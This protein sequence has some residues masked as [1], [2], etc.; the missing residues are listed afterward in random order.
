MFTSKNYISNIDDVPS[1]WIFEYYLGTEPLHGQRIQLKSIFN[2]DDKN[3]SMYIYFD[4]IEQ[5][6]KFKCFSTG[7]FGHAINLVM[8]LTK[9][10]FKNASEQII[11]DYKEFLKTGNHVKGIIYN[12]ER[13]QVCK[14]DTRSFSK[15]DA[16]YWSAYN[17]SSKLLNYWNVV[18]LN[19]YTMC[20]EEKSFDVRGLGI[21]GFFKKNG[22]LY[23]IYQPFIRDRKF[24]KVQDYLQG[25]EQLK[26][27]N[28]L[29][30]VSSMKDGL[31]LLS[32]GLC[33]DFIAPDSENTILDSEVIDQFKQQYKAIC[34]VLD[35]DKA[36]INAM[37][38]Y[39]K[40]YN[41]PFVYF[42][43]EKDLADLVKLRGKDEARIIIVPKINKAL[44][45]YE[46]IQYN[47]CGSSLE[48]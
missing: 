20:N 8:F 10:N 31:A 26:G 33:V 12:N 18:S 9:K 45:K 11:A 44:E 47:L 15:R 30:I 48:L 41:F 1:N 2:S 37:N 39:Y 38:E 27:L 19:T 29:V 6:Y 13:W 7:N 23:K 35:R 28:Y 5:V 25:S 21:Y 3:P 4:P 36:G 34:V 22:D 42:Q 40:R 24:I 17:I 16:D 43:H 32:L 46:E 14:Y